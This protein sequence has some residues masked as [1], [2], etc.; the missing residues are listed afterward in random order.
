M[1]SFLMNFGNPQLVTFLK[2]KSVLDL[3]QIS[4]DNRTG[5]TYFHQQLKSLITWLES[6]VNITSVDI[7]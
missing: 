2:L 7:I 1:V 5:L 4:G 6:K 3:R